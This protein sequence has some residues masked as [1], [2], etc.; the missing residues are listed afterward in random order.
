MKR[1]NLSNPALN[2]NVPIQGQEQREEDITQPVK[3]SRKALGKRRA[4]VD[5]DST[6]A[7]LMS[8]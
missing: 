7:T 2:P 3:P 1:T 8:I 6:F 4:V 5:E